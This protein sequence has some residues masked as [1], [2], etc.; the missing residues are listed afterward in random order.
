M[1]AA[2]WKLA[3]KRLACIVAFS[4]IPVA[5]RLALLP[6]IPPPQPGIQDE[7]SYLLAGDTY[8][9]GRLTNMPH[10]YWVF[11]ESVHIIQQPSYM[12]KYPPLTGLIL[13]F[14][15][16]LFGQPWI[17]ILLSMGVLCG[18][19]AWAV[20]EWMPPFWTVIVSALAVLKIGILSYWSEGYWGGTG[21]AIGGALLI[22]SLPGILRR[23]TFLSGLPAAVGDALLANRRPF[24]GRLLAVLS[25]GYVAWRFA[26]QSTKSA[27]RYRRLIRAVAAPLVVVMVPVGAWMAYYNFRVTG[28]ALVMP[29]VA[30]ERQY[31][32][33]SPFV[34]GGNGPSLT[35]R[36]EAL[37]QAW[38]DWELRK[39]SVMREHFLLTRSLF[40]WWLSEFY[41]GIPLTILV[42]A[43]ARLTLKGRRT[44]APMWLAILFLLGLNVD[45]G[46]FPHYAAPATALFFIL[47]AGALRWLRHWRTRRPWIA[48]MAYS[49]SL[50]C[51]VAQVTAA[52]FWPEHRF[53][54]DRRDFQAERARVVAF[55]NAL[56]GKQLVFV[57]YGP[58]HDIN[59]EWVYNRADI[60]ASTVVWAR[61]MG[62]E[63]DVALIAY[64][65]D[66]Q[67]W[68]L[69][70]NGPARIASYPR[71]LSLGRKSF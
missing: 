1:E 13:A 51:V 39:K 4:L 37:R 55:L 47:A 25:L 28:S 38:V 40:L 5:F 14:G 18:A 68:L 7:F 71:E 50:I 70:E 26:G 8:A 32:G 34:W 60:D 12:S 56:P 22:G 30:H 3:S 69:E 36:H 45:L 35:Y 16:R 53:F 57:R 49:A 15:Q 46:I 29:Y 52:P 41:L 33:A 65:K 11:F 54:Y 58:M 21:A 9:S 20:G 19:L 43:C 66:R 48:C 42:V 67:V 44:R 64:F 2:V 23:R 61:S 27:N 63:K 17:G 62:Q 59:H 31:E 6:W 10:R 24:E